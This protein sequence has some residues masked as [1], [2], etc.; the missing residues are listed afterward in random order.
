MIV[1]K[2]EMEVLGNNKY[3]EN[4]RSHKKSFVQ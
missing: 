2:N 3:F 4:G 1:D